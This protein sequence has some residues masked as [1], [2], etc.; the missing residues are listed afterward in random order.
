MP[1]QNIKTVVSQIGVAVILTFQSYPGHLGRALRL[2]TYAAAS[3][4]NVAAAGFDLGAE[5]KETYKNY[6]L[7]ISSS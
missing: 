7:R 4:S 5:Y 3:C 1:Y 2:H 6:A